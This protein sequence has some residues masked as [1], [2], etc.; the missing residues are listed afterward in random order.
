MSESNSKI[1]DLV[2]EDGEKV[3]L[4]LLNNHTKELRFR[5]I[6]S[7]AIALGIIVYIAWVVG[8]SAWAGWEKLSQEKFASL[9]KIEGVIAP[10]QAAS[11][12][13]I[14]PA[15]KKAFEGDGDSVLLLINSPGGTPTQ[16]YLIYQYIMDLKEET[17]KRVVAVSEDM[18]ASGAFMVSMAADEV[19]APPTAMVGS[20]GVRMESYGF[21]KL[22][23]R[24][25][26]ERRIY[27][28][29]ENKARFDPWMEVTESDREKAGE[30]LSELHS[31]FI[32]IVRT[33]RGDRLALAG[34][35][36]VLFSGD[37]W[38]ATT[39]SQLGL[40]DGV[41]TLEQVIDMLGVDNAIEISPELG[42]QNLLNLLKP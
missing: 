5:T 22:G 1:R 3:F 18:M 6:R 13:T 21:K 30:L 12:Q 26:L 29:G 28:A 16:S 17:G 31:Q 10:Q 2:G 41:K 24:F 25:G 39:A 11:A 20:I 14:N 27:T 37:T 35:E 33:G 9:V 32:D 34:N 7:A 23:E 38:V 36:D 42:F 4:S 19:Y 15:L 8:T 40:I